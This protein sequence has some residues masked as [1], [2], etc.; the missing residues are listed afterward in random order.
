MDILWNVLRLLKR[1]HK[2]STIFIIDLV[3]VLC[4]SSH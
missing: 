1:I 2:V 3:H 4:Q